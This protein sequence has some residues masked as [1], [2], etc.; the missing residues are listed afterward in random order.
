MQLK[1]ETRRHKK[2]ELK[3]RGSA[4]YYVTLAARIKV[5]SLYKSPPAYLKRLERHPPARLLP[6]ELHRSAA[7]R[8]S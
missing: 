8:R 6:L 3:W 1:E 2:K 5:K 4:V 7:R